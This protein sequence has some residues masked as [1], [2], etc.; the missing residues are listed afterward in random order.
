MLFPVHNTGKKLNCGWSSLCFEFDKI[1]IRRL[2]KSGG[3]F[4]V[5]KDVSSAANV[6]QTKIVRNDFWFIACVETF[7]NRD[8]VARK[9]IP[10]ATAAIGDGS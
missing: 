5:T 4:R 6:D 9:V 3:V 2:M 7:S 10:A 8:F 1:V